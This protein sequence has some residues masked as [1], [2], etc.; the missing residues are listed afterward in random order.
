MDQQQLQQAFTSRFGESTETWRC[1]FAP[2]RVNLIGDHIDY[3]GGLVLPCAIENGTTLLVR[4]NGTDLVRVASLDVVGEYDISLSRPPHKETDHWS[5]YPAGVIAQW[6]AQNGVIKGMDCL[7]S[8]N[9][10]TAAGLSSSAALEVVTA[11]ALHCMSFDSAAN[12]VAA[13]LTQLAL[14]CQRA[15][16]DF[17]GVQCGIMDQYASACGQKNHAM[18]LNCQTLE[19]E[20]VPMQLDDCEI[21]LV[22][23]NQQRG[24]SESKY[25]ERVSE[26]TEALSILQHEVDAEQLTAVTPEALEQHQHLFMNKALL[27]QR[28]KHVVSEQDRVQTAAAALKAGDIATVGQLMYASHDSLDQDY[29][30]SSK[31]LNTLVD[32]TRN[33][34]DVLGARLTGA[35]FGGCTVNLVRSQHIEKFMQ[36]VSAHY[37]SITGLSATFI[38]TT[39]GEGVRE[40]STDRGMDN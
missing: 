37:H 11:Y 24:L 18:L 3:H 20:Q 28:A 7:Y 16:N 12:F 13:D 38:R 26:T 22:N 19:C 10:P 39:A 31:P 25:N 5:N 29:A 6:Q 40:L 2:G 4:P 14:L 27:Y 15:E 32:I 34:P 1:F 9:L 36:Q 33:N 23:S 35:G 17:V 30:V 8:G 21:V